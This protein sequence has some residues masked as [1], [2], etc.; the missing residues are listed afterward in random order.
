MEPN[1]AQ[2]APAMETDYVYDTLN[3]LLSVNQWGGLRG[4]PAKNGPI[5]RSFSY[6]SFS[7]LLTAANPETGT[8]GYV[9]DA[10]GN[11]QTKTDARSVTTTYG[12]DALNRV[13]SRTYSSNS[14]GSVS[15]CYSYDTAT[16]GVGRLAFAWTQSASAGTCTSPTAGPLSKRVILAYDSMGRLLG[17][18]QYT[19]ANPVSGGTP[20]SPQYNYDLAGNL[21]YSTDGV[22]PATTTPTSPC[23]SSVTPSWTTLTFA[24]CYDG[25]GRLQSLVSNWI[26]PTHPTSLFAVDSTVSSPPY[27]AF[28]GL[29]GAIFGNGLM[30]NRTYDKR[31]R[32]TGETDSGGIVV[33]PT[34]GSA[35]VTI[36]GSEQSR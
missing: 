29:T 22:S 20:Y 10:N 17:E 6:D 35:T 30:L 19:L 25:A 16:L 26:D 27:A 18:Q 21:T 32:I 15:S 7:R 4:S 3:N 11:V 34:P 36:T 9:Y 23:P 28:G 5:Y 1:G 24:S 12:Y 13:L 33:I 2:Q 31:L 14:N 8:V